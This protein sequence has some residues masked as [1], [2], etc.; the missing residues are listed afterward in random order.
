MPTA[1]RIF[2]TKFAK[3]WFDGEGAFLFGGRWNTRGTR[4]LYAAGSLSLAALEMLVHLDSAELLSSYSYATLECEEKDVL[5]V[6]EFIKL[7]K[8]WSSSPP[9]LAVQRIGDNWAES[10]RSLVLRVPTSVVPG[11]FNYL[12]NVAHPKFSTITRDKPQLFRFD[13]RLYNM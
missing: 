12:V 13:E 7:P 4:V 10:M 11:E 3:T 5:P 8:N 9:P 1:Y 2:K 6:E